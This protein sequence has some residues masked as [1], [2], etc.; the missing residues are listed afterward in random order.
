MD[1]REEKEIRE[2]KKRKDDKHWRE[3]HR[4]WLSFVGG[5][6]L[7]LA[8]IGFSQLFMF[9]GSHINDAQNIV[10]AFKN[11]VCTAPTIINCQK[12]HPQ[13]R[14]MR[15]NAEIMPSHSKCRCQ[16]TASVPDKS[17]CGPH[18]PVRPE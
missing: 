7:F 6:L 16:N 9:A 11:P 5:I 10:V 1:I 17:C 3:D 15:E 14:P 2:D 13:M 8:G 12:P 18:I 4:C